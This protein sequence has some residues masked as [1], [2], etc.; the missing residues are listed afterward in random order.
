MIDD[1]LISDELSEVQPGEQEIVPE[2]SE[3]EVIISDPLLESEVN[4]ANAVYDVEY[5]KNGLCARDT[6]TMTVV[7]FGTCVNY[8]SY[9]V[10]VS[11]LSLFF[12]LVLGFILA[13]AVSDGWT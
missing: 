7:E 3:Q 9:E 1:D 13:K 6:E 5:L 4:P 11:Y 8:A 12:G 2:E 10:G